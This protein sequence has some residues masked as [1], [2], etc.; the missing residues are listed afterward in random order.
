MELLLVLAPLLLGAP[1]VADDLP[2]VVLIG[3]SIRIGYEPFVAERLQGKAR[4]VSPGEENGG[5]SANVLKNLE[6]WAI[7]PKPAVV[8]FNCGLHDLK[9][10][11]K[12]GTH[13]V[14]PDAYRANL[15]AIRKRLEQETTARLIFATTTPVLDDRHRATKP[16]DRREAD[17]ALYN[18]IA[19]E[20]LSGESVII[21][22]LHASA[23]KLGLETALLQDGVHFQEAASKALAETVASAIERA[24]IDPPVTRKV[25][26]RRADTP[27]KL[28]GVADE[29]AWARAGVIDRFPTFWKGQDP[30]ATTRARLLWNDDA[31]YFAAEMTDAELRSFGSRRNDKLWNGDVFE[32]FFKPST[33]R[34]EYYE[35]QVN[36]KSVIL[37]LAFPRRGHDFDELAAQPPMGFQAVARVDGT[38]DRSGDAD[39]GWTVEGRIPWSLFAPT[40]GRPRPGDAWAFALCRYDYGPEGTEPILTSSAPLRRPSFH[41]YEDYGTLNFE[42]ARR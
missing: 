26:C 21:S 16:F 2:T 29:P 4:V 17:V 9:V 34:P 8:Y 12:T 36:P 25:L 1:P 41:R 19:R 28:D 18:R 38:L 10:D 31:L 40:G 24:L 30:G 5:D 14:E 3:D 22:D 27:P 33:D 37:E 6:R 42:G 32:L 11:R 7:S 20:A 13:Q 39:R 35:F 15:A 23:Q